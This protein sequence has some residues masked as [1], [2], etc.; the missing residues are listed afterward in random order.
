MY[1]NTHIHTPF[2]FSS[3]DSIDQA[4]MLAKEE[5]IGVLGI[6]DF[7]TIDG[8]ELFAE[9]CEK[10]SVFPIFN[11]EFAALIE[12]DRVRGL[13]WN[14]ITYPGI[15]YLCG[16][17]LNFPIKLNCDSKNLLAS[18]WKVSQDRIWRIINN[19]NEYLHSLELDITLDYQKIRYLYAKHAVRERHLAKALYMAFVEK[20]SDPNLLM[21]KFRNLFK[22]DTFTADLAD[23]VLLQNEIKNR[24][25]RPGM[26]GY[27]NEN[28]ATHVKFFEAKSLIL[29]S[30]GIP[31]Y[32]VYLDGSQDMT[33]KERSVTT[34]IDCLLELEIHAVEFISNRVTFDKLKNYVRAFHEK[35]FC[36]SFGTEHCTLERYSLIPGTLGG[37]PFDIELEE[38]AYEG[39]CIYAAH[40]QLHTLC[41]PGFVDDTGKLIIHRN[42]LKNFARIGEEAIKKVTQNETTILH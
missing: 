25:F 1:V 35:G 5:E 31:C 36:V 24:L 28:Y 34:L 23:A 7:N 19:I 20:W 22:D 30:G 32:P 21:E 15:M 9:V 18:V 4:V 38:I 17:A 42:Q 11:I 10:Y 8:H 2:S 39:A 16:K 26:V 27:I 41:R 3:F 29:S 12:E 33:E 6:N 13:R 40:Q 14:D 37:R